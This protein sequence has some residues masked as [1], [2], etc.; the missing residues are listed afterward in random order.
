MNPSTSIQ[1]PTT[2]PLSWSIYQTP[3]AADYAPHKAT[4][5]L[6]TWKAKP[7][8]EDAL[9]NS[10]HRH[11]MEYF[12]PQKKPRNRKC[13][14]IWFNPPFN[15]NMT[16]NFARNFLDLLDKH[17][18]HH[19]QYHKPFNRNNVKT[20]FSCMGNMATIT[21]GQNAKILNPAPPEDPRTCNCGRPD[22]KL[23]MPNQVCRVQSHCHSPSKTCSTLLWT[24]WGPL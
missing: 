9:K 3:S 23:K 12:M 10:G 4:V 6:S 15:Q 24:N 5:E 21:S 8:Y 18:P 2:H 16:T 14:V 20:S 11:I 22:T 13:N 7:I 1:N 19:H 17:F